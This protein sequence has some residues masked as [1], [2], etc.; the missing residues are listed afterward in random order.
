MTPT[1]FQLH[2]STGAAARTIATATGEIDATNAVDFARAV[3]DLPGPRPAILD[4]SRVSYLDSS[5]FAQLDR[6][7]G[8]QAVVIVLSAASHLRRAADIVGMPYHDS[9]DTAAHTL[10]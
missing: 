8:H 9:V 6:L 4:L 3:A 7:L 2:V 5:G 10:N 1:S